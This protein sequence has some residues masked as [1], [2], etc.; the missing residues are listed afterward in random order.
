MLAP[1]IFLNKTSD[2]PQAMVDPDLTEQDMELI[3]AQFLNV[4]RA[5]AKNGNR[6]K[7]D[8][9]QDSTSPKYIVSKLPNHFELLGLIAKVFPNA[10]II[11]TT[12][13]VRDVILS[14]YQMNYQSGHHWSYNLTEAASYYAGYRSMMKHWEM[15]F[16]PPLPAGLSLPMME[17]RCQNIYL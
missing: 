1:R 17:I 5:H 12:R 8:N 10:P 2:K 6:N 14:N 15:V 11:H 3:G 9:D 7:K 16:K 13:D 4:L